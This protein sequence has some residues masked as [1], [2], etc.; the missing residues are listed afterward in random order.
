V[1]SAECV[2]RELKRADIIVMDNV[3]VHGV[4]GVREAKGVREQLSFVVRS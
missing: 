3:G 4:A 1:T 2:I